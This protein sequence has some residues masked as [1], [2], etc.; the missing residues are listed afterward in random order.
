MKLCFLIDC[1]SL[2]SRTPA[3]KAYLMSKLANN[4]YISTF[5]A[6]KVNIVKVFCKKSTVLHPKI[7]LKESVHLTKLLSM[8]GQVSIA[9]ILGCNGQT[10][11]PAPVYFWDNVGSLGVQHIMIEF[12]CQSRALL[13]LLVQIA[14]MGLILPRW[15]LILPRITPGPPTPFLYSAVTQKVNNLDHPKRSMTNSLQLCSTCS[16]FWLHL[17]SLWPEN[18]CLAPCPFN[19]L[20]EGALNINS[21][22]ICC[23]KQYHIRSISDIMTEAWYSQ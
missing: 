17:G 22:W 10:W 15:G 2:V 4:S 13:P 6:D 21:R 8:E 20:V 18:L 7:N 16:Q 9:F 3:G 11:D 14:Q 19:G 23:S 12:F 5:S 1:L